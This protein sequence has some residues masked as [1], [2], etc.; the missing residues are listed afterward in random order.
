MG[1]ATRLGLSSCNQCSSGQRKALTWQCLLVI[2]LQEIISKQN[3][4]AYWKMI[5]EP[6]EVRHTH[7]ASIFGNHDTMPFETGY[8]L[9]TAIRQNSCSLTPLFD[10]QCRS[11]RRTSRTLYRRTTSTY[12]LIKQTTLLLGFG[13]STRAVDHFPEHIYAD[14]INWFVRTSKELPRLQS[15]SRFFIPLPE[16]SEAIQSGKSA[17]E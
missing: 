14:R 15:R 7:F 2:K 16:Y 13:S 17:L 9:S 10:I 11:L 4:T 8:E 12:S 5:V 3:A 6:C 1:A